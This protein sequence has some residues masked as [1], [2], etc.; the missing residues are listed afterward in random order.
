MSDNT[1]I[2][3]PEVIDKSIFRE[4]LEKLQQESWQLELIISGFVLYG[5]YNS[6]GV[7]TDLEFYNLEHS[8][9]IFLNSLET[10]LSTGWRIFFIN[11]LVHVVFRSLWIGA[12]GLRY[13]S[14][15][16]NYEQLNYS[17]VFTNYLKKKVGDYDDFIEKLEKICSVLFSYTFLLFLFFVSII[18]SGM[19]LIIPFVIID[20]LG[21]DP[22]ESIIYFVL[23]FFPYAGFGAIVFLD[24]ITL[25]GIKRIKDRTVSKIFMPIYWFYSHITLSFLYRPLL[26]NFI[27]DKYT[28]KLFFFSFPYIFLIANCDS[29]YENVPNPYIASDRSLVEKGLVVDP[30]YYDDLYDNHLSMQS[31]D[32]KRKNKRVGSLRISNYKVTEPYLQLFVM[33]NRNYEDVLAK[34]N[35]LPIYKDGWN[36]SFFSDNLRKRDS[37]QVALKD[38][39][40]VGERI[41]YEEFKIYRDSIKKI[42]DDEGLK[43]SLILKRDSL[44]D[45]RTKLTDKRNKAL[46]EFQAQKEKRILYTMKDQAKLKIDNIMYDDSVSYYYGEHHLRGNKGILY[47]I[48]M[49][50]L[51]VGEHII[52]IDLFEN[53]FEKTDSVSRRKYM[54]PI[55]KL[56]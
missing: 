9:N 38:S 29:F 51:D 32:D 5:I 26:Y 22:E 49:H 13:V 33:H 15:E 42:K 7:I 45:R 44:N 23:W 41:V 35:I 28:R 11:L 14:G 10:I 19:F 8:R 20:W 54:L 55:L 12:I 48:P 24:F 1:D 3:D 37:I 21:G 46:V 39:F 25:G 53:Y 4:W 56:K 40:K 47:N 43:N 2:N 6:K 36:F 17:E 27:D 34:K 16:I 31:D 30:Y 52:E 50:H 18:F